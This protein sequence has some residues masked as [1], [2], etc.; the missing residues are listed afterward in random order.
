MRCLRE[1]L[2]LLSSKRN[3][4]YNINIITR[5]EYFNLDLLFFFLPS[6]SGVENYVK[7]ENVLL[8]VGVEKNVN[9]LEGIVNIY[10]SGKKYKKW[11]WKKKIIMIF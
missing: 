9:I 4:K 5:L 6:E 3:I 2:L 11:M 7:V 10:W 8:Q 1:E